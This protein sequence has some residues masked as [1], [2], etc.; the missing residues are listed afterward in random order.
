M[1]ACIYS[2]EVSKYSM[3]RGTGIG[4]KNWKNRF[5]KITRG[6]LQLYDSQTA[7]NPK[8]EI[9]HNAIS[10]LFTNPDGSL[11][12]EAKSK[13]PMIL[14]RLFENGVFNLLIKMESEEAKQKWIAALREANKNNKGFQVIVDMF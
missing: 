9:P 10:I 5:L 3:G 11:H 4:A 13:V 2:G 14:L 1:E 8:F 12:P 6:H 7:T